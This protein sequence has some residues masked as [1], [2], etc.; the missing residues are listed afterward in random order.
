MSGPTYRRI[1]DG[2]PHRER[3]VLGYIA[4][5]LDGGHPEATLRKLAALGLIVGTPVLLPGHPTVTITRWDT[6]IA[7]HMAWCAWCAD[8]PDS[9]D[10][11]AAL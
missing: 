8:S 1:I 10:D 9:D 6:P 3:N 11:E 2:L 7:V 5:N 4:I